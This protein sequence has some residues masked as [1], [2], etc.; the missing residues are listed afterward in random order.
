MKKV[1]LQKIARDAP[2]EEIAKFREEMKSE[3]TSP[4]QMQQLAEQQ[5]R[6]QKAAQ[7]MKV[8]QQRQ[9]SERQRQAEE[10]RQQL[11]QSRGKDLGNDNGPGHYR[12]PRR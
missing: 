6:E 7:E 9:E 3:Y 4:R 8:A 5:E 1:I 10:A 12:G 11:R 2:A